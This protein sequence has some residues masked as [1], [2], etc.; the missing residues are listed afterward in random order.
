[1]GENVV[2]LCKK[3]ALKVEQFSEAAWAGA[4]EVMSELGSQALHVVDM[5][6][7]APISIPVKATNATLSGLGSIFGWP[8]AYLFERPRDSI[9]EDI[10]NEN[11]LRAG[12]KIAAA[13][14]LSPFVIFGGL[15]R[16][17]GKLCD[18]GQ[19]F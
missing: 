17:V 9:L 12:L 13:F 15:C 14:V 8:G 3:G 2:D 18:A 4:K 16:G 6:L 7:A 11:N 19:N 1:V 10:N 5:T